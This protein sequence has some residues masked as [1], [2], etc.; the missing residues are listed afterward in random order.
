[1]AWKLNNETLPRPQGFERA[2]LETSS[3]IRTAGGK[4]IK[5]VTNRKMQY[6]LQYEYLTQTERTQLYDLL[7]LDTAI[8]FEVTEGNLTIATTSVIMDISNEQFPAK[9]TSFR[10]NLN[11]ILTEVI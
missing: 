4:T 5:Q 9:G 1:M 8:D 11:I 2:T 3:T 10:E 6:T 7:E